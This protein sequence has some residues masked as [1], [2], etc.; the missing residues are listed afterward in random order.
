MV[1]Q[2]AGREVEHVVARGVLVDA[3][4]HARPRLRAAHEADLGGPPLPGQLALRAV[5]E[6]V[7]VEALRS[8]RGGDRLGDE[9]GGGAARA[10]LRRLG[11]VKVT[12]VELARLRRA[13]RAEAVSGGGSARAGRG[14]RGARARAGP[15]PRRPSPGGTAGWIFGGKTRTSTTPADG[16]AG[17]GDAKAAVT[18][19]RISSLVGKRAKTSG[20]GER[21]ARHCGT[22]TKRTSTL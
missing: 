6:V 12:E 8:A 22:S 3:L 15:S 17:G 5:G 11:A 18:P 19:V 21:R 14:G 10:V 16:G 7:R 13:G 4:H 9:R 20:S 1:A 2:Q